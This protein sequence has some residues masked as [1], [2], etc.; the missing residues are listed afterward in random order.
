[1]C[2]TAVRNGKWSDWYGYR[3]TRALQKA[4]GGELGLLSQMYA[5]AVDN[6]LISS[7]NTKIAIV[8]CLAITN[9]ANWLQSI[10]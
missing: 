9:I 2:K 5:M 1:M 6:R 7:R 10:T 8:K 3:N 4:S